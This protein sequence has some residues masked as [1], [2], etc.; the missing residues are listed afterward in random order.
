MNYVIK[1][2][3]GISLIVGAGLLWWLEKKKESVEHRIKDLYDEDFLEQKAIHKIIE[4]RKNSVSQKINMD[5]LK[6]KI[7]EKPL[8]FE[9]VPVSASDTINMKMPLMQ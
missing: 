4:E 5:N 9:S 6:K 7:Q 8:I 2:I 1:G 3:I